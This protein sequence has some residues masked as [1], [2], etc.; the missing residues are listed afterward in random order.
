MPFINLGDSGLFSCVRGKVF[1]TTIVTDALI[2]ITA[3]T[4]T[5][6]LLLSIEIIGVYYSWYKISDPYNVR[7]IDIFQLSI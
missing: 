2:I 6:L 5:V 4:T 3:I 1:I 7:D